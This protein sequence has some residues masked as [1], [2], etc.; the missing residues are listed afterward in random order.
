[1]RA[2]RFGLGVLGVAAMAY[3]LGGAAGDPDIVPRRQVAFLL[4]VLVLHDAALLPGFLLVGLLVHRFV[5]ARYRG[6]VQAAL[7]VTAAVTFVALPLVL[8]YGR[9]A[10]NPS[11]LPRDYPAG[12][13]LV[14]GA[15]WVVAAAALLATRLRSRRR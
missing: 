11:A 7:A 8:G 10:D 6:I 12:L 3:A 13:A 15:V 4:T 14:L 9:S 5:A 2:V 1:V